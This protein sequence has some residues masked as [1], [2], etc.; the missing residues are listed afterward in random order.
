MCARCPVAQHLSLL[1]N[2][3]GRRGA[4]ALAESLGENRTLATLDLRLNLID[5]HEL[6]V[7]CMPTADRSSAVAA[8]PPPPLQAIMQRRRQSASIGSAWR[9]QSYGVSTDDPPPSVDA[10]AAGADRLSVESTDAQSCLPLHAG[11]RRYTSSPGAKNSPCLSSAHARLT[12]VVVREAGERGTDAPTSSPAGALSLGAKR[13]ET[14]LEAARAVLG[15][16]QDEHHAEHEQASIGLLPSRLQRSLEEVANGPSHERADGSSW[17]HERLPSGAAHSASRD[18]PSGASRTSADVASRIRDAAGSKEISATSDTPLLTEA[19]QA[20][21]DE[22]WRQTRGAPRPDEQPRVPPSLAAPPQPPEARPG[23]RATAESP[24]QLAL[25]TVSGVP[26][27]F[28]SLD[29][30]QDL[31]A[32]SAAAPL[33]ASEAACDALLDQL[34]LETQSVSRRKPYKRVL[35]PVQSIRAP[36]LPPVLTPGRYSFVKFTRGCV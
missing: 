28:R 13:A 36:T 1:H 8:P 14:L 17:P 27:E 12:L 22:R 19:A 4:H 31:E 25:S 34:D 35:L 15:H 21:R 30:S 29:V 7:Q 3:I 23:L 33:G 11:S 6:Q 20:A 18:A 32:S 2:A 9:P 26:L 16:T 24:S 5:E 10:G